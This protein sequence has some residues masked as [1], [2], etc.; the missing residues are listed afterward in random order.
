MSANETDGEGCLMEHGLL[1]R[2]IKPVNT[3][4]D[5]RLID[6]DL[7]VPADGREGAESF[8]TPLGSRIYMPP[9]IYRGKGGRPWSDFYSLGM[10]ALLMMGD[11]RAQ[12]LL[13]TLKG[14]DLI[15]LRSARFEVLRKE[16]ELEAAVQKLSEEARS[17]ALK[18]L[19]FARAALKDDPDR[20]PKTAGEYLQILEDGGNVGEV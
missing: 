5:G 16:K 17:D 19:R 18:V 20:R 10:T 9:E 13:K 12:R 4:V 2:D 15:W 7:L 1:H 6:I 8:Y 14:D 3:L 11:D